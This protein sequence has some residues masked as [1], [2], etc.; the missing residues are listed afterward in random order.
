MVV[1]YFPTKNLTTDH[2]HLDVPVLMELRLSKT[3]RGTMPVSS[4][5]LC[6]LS[7]LEVQQL[8]FYHMMELLSSWI[9]LPGMK[10][11]IY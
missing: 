6:I 1:D 10:R 4:V 2:H 7:G 11:H 8:Q 5:V 3:W 9:S